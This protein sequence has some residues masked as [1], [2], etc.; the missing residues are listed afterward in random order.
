MG[1]FVNLFAKR[2]FAQEAF[3]E[4]LAAQ[5]VTLKPGGLIRSERA[6]PATGR[7]LFSLKANGEFEAVNAAIR[8]RI[9]ATF[10]KMVFLRG[11]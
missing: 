11:K 5:A 9:D 4:E 1:W 6:D 8:G 7:P 2:L 10:S 3:I